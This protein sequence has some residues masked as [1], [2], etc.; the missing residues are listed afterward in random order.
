MKLVIVRHGETEE[1]R[2]GI[3]QGYKRG[4]LSELGKKQAAEVA[5]KLKNEKFTAIYSSDLKRCRDTVESIASYHKENIVHYTEAL[6]EMSIGNIDKYT[7][8]LPKKLLKY[9]FRIAT[10][11]NLKAPGGESWKSM[12]KREVALLNSLYDQYPNGTV[13]LITHS[14]TMQAINSI[15]KNKKERDLRFDKVPNGAVWRI[16]MTQKINLK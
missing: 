16:E 1:N 11:L 10:F 5:I 15:F 2:L 13:L 6:R 12:L 7:I 3:V 8:R 14:I 4:S 9:G